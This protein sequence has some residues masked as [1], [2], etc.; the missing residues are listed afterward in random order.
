MDMS[1][2]RSDSGTSQSRIVST[3][4]VLGGKPR[5]DGTRIGVYFVHER[6]EGRGLEPQTVADRHDLDIA[7]VYRALVYYHDH[8]DEMARIERERAELRENATSD[9]NVASGPTDLE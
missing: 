1:G 8:P 9:P 4:D 6:V 3:E 2:T 5:I 7:D